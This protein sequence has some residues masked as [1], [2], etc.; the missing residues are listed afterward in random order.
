LEAW[1]GV[2]RVLLL[3]VAFFFFLLLTYLASSAIIPLLH[4]L[5]EQ[6]NRRVSGL[7]P[8]KSVCRPICIP[9]KTQVLLTSPEKEELTRKPRLISTIKNYQPNHYKERS[10]TI[11]S[12]R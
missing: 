2:E 7:L 11:G 8:Y 6:P 5:S 1:V 3:Y 9:T 10:E 12:K 4:G